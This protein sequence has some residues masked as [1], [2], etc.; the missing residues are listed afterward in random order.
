MKRGDIFPS[1]YLKAADLNGKSPS[2][3]RSRTR[4]PRPSKPVAATDAKPCSTLPRWQ[5][6]AVA[7]EHDQLGRGFRHR[8]RRYRRLAGASDRI[9]P[10]HDGDEGQRSSTASASGRPQ[11]TLPLAARPGATP[12]PMPAETSPVEAY[13]D[14]DFGDD[15]PEAFR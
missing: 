1:K 6:E 14:A 8:R 15:L 3:L 5:G 9:V 12:A 4:P 11:G 13:A 2:S 7:V 10:D